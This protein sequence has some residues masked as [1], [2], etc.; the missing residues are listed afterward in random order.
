[1][2]KKLG[3]IALLAAV[4]GAANAGQVVCTIQYLWGIIP[5]GETCTSTGGNGHGGSPAA[6]PEIDPGSAMAALTLVTGGLVVLRGR[7]KNK[8]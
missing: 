3:L 6:A 1:M 8:N 7:R 4:S 2:I 5:I